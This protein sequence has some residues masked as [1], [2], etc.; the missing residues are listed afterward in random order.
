MAATFDWNE[1][2]GTQTG[3]PAKGTTRSTGVTQVNWKNSGVYADAYSAYPITAGNNS[4]AKYIFGKFT[5]TFNQI[6]G[7]KFAH[8]A[9]TLGTGLTLVSKITTTYE[10][11][12]TTALS[13][14]T[15][16]TSITAIASGAT[17]QFG[18][19]GPEAAGKA[20]SSTE[21]TTYSEYIVTQL[22]T[23]SNAAPG[24]TATVTLTLRYLEN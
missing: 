19:T 13:G 3:S 9:G 4:F 7:G 18:G 22:Q 20:A 12:S 10:T 16:I 11:P 8:T 6:S 23:A 1:D 17:V 5:G 2:T 24:D 14:S 21:A 15:D